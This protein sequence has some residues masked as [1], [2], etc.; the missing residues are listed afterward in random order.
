MVRRMWLFTISYCE[1][2]LYN[3]CC[4]VSYRLCHLRLS[5]APRAMPSRN[6][7][8]L[9]GYGYFRFKLYTEGIT[10]LIIFCLFIQL[11]YSSFYFIVL[12][13]YLYNCCNNNYFDILWWCLSVYLFIVGRGLD[14]HIFWWQFLTF[15]FPWQPLFNFLQCLKM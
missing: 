13:F 5:L 2:R 1:L 11:C 4:L 9:E 12:W 14:M 7:V 6:S 8:I 3:V 10:A 15:V